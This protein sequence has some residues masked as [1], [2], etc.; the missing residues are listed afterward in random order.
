M[1]EL[2]KTY[3]EEKNARIRQRILGVK[4]YL[5]D[6]FREYRVA[7]VL[8]VSYSTV[9]KWVAKY[10]RGGVGA[11]RDRPRSGR[12]RKYSSEEVKKVLETSP[13]ELGYNLEGWTMRAL[14]AELRK[15]GIV[16]NRYH[17]YR[18]VHQLGYGFVTPRPVNA[19]A[20]VEKHRDF[21]KSEGTDGTQDSVLR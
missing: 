1:E 7:E 10:K 3:R 18:V 16:Y 20:E 4:M 13:R 11:L 17:L 14:N 2:E 12:P 5:V 21:K 9:K 19:R 6:G 8:G 15:R